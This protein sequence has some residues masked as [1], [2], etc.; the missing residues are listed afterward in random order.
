MDINTNI[1]KTLATILSEHGLSELEVEQGDFKVR[2]ARDLKNSP[3]LTP[4]TLPATLPM[5]FVPP[6]LTTV[7]SMSVTSGV[8]NSLGG[9]APNA[10]VANAG[11]GIATNGGASNGSSTSQN[12]CSTINS[13]L[14]GIFYAQESPDSEPYVS[15]G[16]TISKGDV[17]YILE[18]MKTMNEIVSDIDGEIVEILA[19]NGQLVEFGQ[20]L[21]RYKTI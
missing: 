21:F 20:P 18:A 9:I 12:S 19:T 4:M 6:A 10:S 3:Y 16:K 14:V 15:V 8:A 17:L 1:I 2:V 13:K 5:D 7:D 11:A